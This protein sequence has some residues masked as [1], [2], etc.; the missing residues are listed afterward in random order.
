[1]KPRKI[2]FIRLNLVKAY[3]SPFD[4]W[5][6]NGKSD[7]TNEKIIWQ[8]LWFGVNENQSSDCIIQSSAKADKS[9]LLRGV[10][11]YAR[12]SHVMGLISDKKKKVCEKIEMSPAN[13]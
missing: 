8:R 11:V 13:P 9:H 4:T 3:F 10:L 12:L 5:R 1:M 7:V 2:N 6:A